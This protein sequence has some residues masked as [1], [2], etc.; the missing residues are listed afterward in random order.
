MLLPSSISLERANDTGDLVQFAVEE[1]NKR[2]G[3]LMSGIFCAFNAIKTDPLKTGEL[4]HRA[5]VRRSIIANEAKIAAILKRVIFEY[6][7][8][9]E[10]V[11]QSRLVTF[12]I[13]ELE[14]VS[15]NALF[16]LQVLEAIT[17]EIQTILAEKT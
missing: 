17:D 1:M 5:V 7:E 8:E 4:L 10:S 15:R 12:A 14:S 11:A 13:S 16:S 3:I 9:V 6:C 2:A